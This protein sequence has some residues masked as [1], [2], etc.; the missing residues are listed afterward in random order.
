MHFG[1]PEYDG[2]DLRT[3]PGK[4]VKIINHING[5]ADAT[6]NEAEDRKSNPRTSMAPTDI[7]ITPTLIDDDHFFVFRS[8][9]E[10]ESPR[11][12]T[13][14]AQVQEHLFEVVLDGDDAFLHYKAEDGLKYFLTSVEA[15]TLVGLTRQAAFREAQS[16]PID[17][18]LI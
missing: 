13:G 8:W 5:L 16:Y 4:A 9:V 10:S 14:V 17:R 2:T 15:L 1:A 3:F 12:K 11:G 6:I 7:Q 18:D